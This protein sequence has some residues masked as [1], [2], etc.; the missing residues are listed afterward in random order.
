MF[1]VFLMIAED[2]DLHGIVFLMGGIKKKWIL[3]HK[4]KDIKKKKLIR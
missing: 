1:F 4:D 3:K 2:L